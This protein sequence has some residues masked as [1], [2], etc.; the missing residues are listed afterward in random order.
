[1][2]AFIAKLKKTVAEPVA[3]ATWVVFALVVTVTGPFGSYESSPLWMRAIVSSLIMVCA[4]MIGST[5]RVFVYHFFPSFGFMRGT[6]AITLLSLII[7]PPPIY[8][9]L[10]Y[11]AGKGRLDVPDP[12]NLFLLVGTMSLAIS[13][14]RNIA[15]K[16]KLAEL[17]AVKVESLPAMMPMAFFD[18]PKPMESRLLQRV[19]PELR[20]DLYA[21]SVRDHY[22]DV[23]TSV[24]SASLLLRLG[25]AMLEAEPTEGTQV[26]RSHWVAWDAVSGVESEAGKLFV[27]LHN[28]NRLPVSKNHREKLKERELI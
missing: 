19:E 17:A 11:L 21:I 28:G 10:V 25:D 13:A 22:V 2:S 5:I 27:R 9:I 12:V 15:Q 23:Q 6:A 18:A 7:L 16:A 1:M 3:I 26:H 8:G 4:G 20:G 14:L 24:G